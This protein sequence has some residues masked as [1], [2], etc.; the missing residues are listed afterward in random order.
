MKKPAKV[1]NL[2]KRV[3]QAADIL[4]FSAFLTVSLLFLFRIRKKPILILC[5]FGFVLLLTVLT[6]A[7]MRSRRKL[8]EK[9]KEEER[10]RTERLLLMSDEEIG[11][12]LGVPSFYLIRREH[13]EPFDILEPIRLK[14]E[15]IGILEHHVE[16]DKLIKRY[17][18]SATVIEKDEMMRRVF[19]S[20]PNDGRKKTVFG[21]ME[22]DKVNKYLILGIVL[23][24]C[25]FMV[26][27][28]IYYRTV[29][30]L[31]LIIAT[32]TGF[33]RSRFPGKNFRIFLDKRGDR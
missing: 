6:D 9:R 33:F 30:V 29:S 18:Q 28:K 17:A 7:C 27:T 1:I 14:K 4:I 26:R 16:T 15:T 11:S 25:S 21:F 10:Q 13:P 5:V 24:V 22:F 12:V 23:F 8:K 19:G 32:L 31:C 3:F 2:L 20:D